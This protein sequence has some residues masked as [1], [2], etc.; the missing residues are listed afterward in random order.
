MNDEQATHRMD[1]RSNYHH[2]SWP[3]IYHLTLKVNN[4]LRQPLG[5]VV[6]DSR[7]ADGTP[8]APRVE[9]S[10]IGIMV[11]R[12][13]TT[14]ITRHYPMVEIHDHVVMPDHLHALIVVRRRIVSANGREAHLGQVIAGFKKGCNR[15]FWEMTGQQG[16]LAEQRGEPAVTRTQPSTAAAA[17]AADAAAAAGPAAAGVAEPTAAA[18]AEGVCPAVSP[19]GCRVPSRAT[20]GRPP[21]FSYGYV[22]VMPVDEAQLETQ[23]QY[24]RNNPR[25]RLMR[26]QNR[27]WLQPQRLA[28][29]TALSFTALKG[30]LQRECHPSLLSA[31][32]WPQLYHR[33]LL[34]NGLVMCDSYGN[35]RLALGRLLPVVCHRKDS[36]LFEY[37]KQTCL[38]AAGSGAVLVSARIAG[39]EKTIIDAAI[40]A[41]L[42]VILVA[43]NGFPDIY[44][45][46]EQ[47]IRLCSQGS[48]LLVSPWHYAYRRADDAISV[49]MCKTMNCVVQSLCRQKDSWWKEPQ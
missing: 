13:L 39:G 5:R 47:R 15:C 44:H 34:S 40:A 28:V 17:D 31:D 33:L 25:S 7:E 24:I 27:Q 9:L 22:D 32:T 21:L 10:E 1:R 19:Q 46:S 11:E 36:S 12:E 16:T 3:G 37:Q 30:Y 43:D 23:R 18:A 41:S 42:P 4:I 8:G 49:V 26:T 45:P 29:S 6:G 2:Y 20:T 14:S 35:R 38:A 48:V